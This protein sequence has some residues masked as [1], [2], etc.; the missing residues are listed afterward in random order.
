MN[1]NTKCY[2][3]YLYRFLT[4]TFED[5]V[6]EVTLVKASVGPLV[7]TSTILF[8]Q[9][10]FT[11]KLDPSLLPCL[12]TEPVLVVIHPFALVGGALGVDEG[13][14]AIGHSIHPLT[15]I[16]ATIR[17]DHA[18]QPLHLVLAEL[19]LVLRTVRPDQDAQTVLHL[20]ALYKTPTAHK[21]GGMHKF[22]DNCYGGRVPQWR[23]RRRLTIAPG[24]S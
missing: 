2:I 8:A 17:L 5:A 4:L 1:V 14:L 3:L 23:E 7:A 16:H 9:L 21:R 11:F 10:V 18:T 12:L 24:I 13:A 6:N 20:A 15:L 22:C 19:A